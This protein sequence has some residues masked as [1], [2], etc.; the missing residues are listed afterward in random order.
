MRWRVLAWL[1]IAWLLPATSPAVTCGTP[2]A[3]TKVSAGGPK[4]AGAAST[5]AMLRDCLLD[6]SHGF[7]PVAFDGTGVSARAKKLAVAAAAR[8]SGGEP[9][10]F[11][12]YIDMGL[13]SSENLLTIQRISEIKIFTLAF[14]L[15]PGDCSA[16]WQ[17]VGSI[18]NDMLPNGRTILSLVQSLRAIGA[19]VIIS[20]GGAKGDEPALHCPDAASLTAVYQ[21]VIDRYKVKALDFDIEGDEVL[22]Q[23]S[24]QR[25]NQALVALRAANPGLTISY[26][27]PALPSGLDVNGL[28][29]LTSAKRDGFNPDV[30]NVLAMNYGASVDN[31]GQ[32]GQDAVLASSNTALQVKAAGLTS[33][34]GIIPMIGVN[35]VSSEV[36]TLADA[37]LLASFAASNADIARLSMWS[38]SRDNGSCAGATAAVP[39][40]SGIAQS[41]YAFSAIFEAR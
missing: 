35:D 14:V 9:V 40:C 10:M 28:A 34:I 41:P 37:R 18:T 23:R 8:E 3:A 15:S 6:N 5:K 27:L 17:G 31:G 7:S 12:P 11:A 22:D 19:D 25:R 30:I 13:T 16:A 39:T 24:I 4:G 36:F 20:F 32:M 29:V 26:T 21:S 38:V 33:R 1:G 2:S